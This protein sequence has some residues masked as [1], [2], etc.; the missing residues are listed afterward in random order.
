MIESDHIFC[1]QTRDNEAG[2]EGKA[3]TPVLYSE[4]QDG[5]QFKIIVCFPQTPSVIHV[6]MWFFG[7]TTTNWVSQVQTGIYLVWRVDSRT[8]TSKTASFSTNIPVIC[9]FQ[10]TESSDQNCLYHCNF[11]WQFHGYC[12]V[13][14]DG[15][16]MR[17]VLDLIVKT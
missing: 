14:D 12:F 4:I 16:A 13:S 3:L 5:T 17:F 7:L 8:R 2:R 10:S 1:S 11:C 15:K 9:F 6:V